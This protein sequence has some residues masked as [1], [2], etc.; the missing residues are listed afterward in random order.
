MAGWSELSSV[1]DADLSAAAAV[2]ASPAALTSAAFD[3]D[4]E[5][6]WTGNEH[7][8]VAS[9]VGGEI[10]KYT[11]FRAHQGPVRQLIPV[12]T[13]V[14]S[15]GPQSVRLTNRR[16][17]V[18]WTIS[19]PMLTQ[20][21]YCM[22]P[23]ALRHSDVIVA[24][25]QR[26]ALMVNVDRGTIIRKFDCDSDI[27]VLRRSQL[28][29][30]GTATGEVMLRDPR[31]FRVEHAVQ[32]H[33]GT[34]SDIAV[35]DNYLLTCGYS[36]RHGELVIDPLVKV[37][38]LRSMRPL[39]P[40]SFVAGP[41]FLKLHPIKP[42]SVF[43]AAQ[44]GQFQTCDIG[45]PAAQVQFYQANT[46]S[47]ITAFD[48]SPSGEL[49]AFGD[50]SSV[51]SLW[52]DSMHPRVNMSG[53]MPEMA[54]STHLPPS[55][56]MTDD[57]HVL[58]AIERVYVP[59][60]LSAWPSHMIFEVGRPAEAIDTEVLDQMKTVDFV[61][62][63]PNPGTRL[64]NQVSSSYRKY[65]TA[66]TMHTDLDLDVDP[67]SDNEWSARA[68]EMPKYYRKVEI[69]Y[70]KFGVEDFDFGY[71][72]KT[73]FG[74]L[75]THITNSYCNA[76]LQ[77][78]RFLPGVGVA[79][80]LH[81]AQECTKEYCLCCELG[82]LLRMLEAAD[83]ANCQASNFLR[84]FGTIPEAS[85][86]GLFEPETPEPRTSYSALI[87][88]FNRF[89][90]EQ[91]HQEC[92]STMLVRPTEMEKSLAGDETIGEDAGATSPIKQLFGIPMVTQSQC[93][94]GEM[95]QR[96]SSPFTVDMAYAAKSVDMAG[97][98]SRPF[99]DI[100]RSSLT[101]ESQTRAWCDRCR[102][103][104]PT[105]QHKRLRGLPVILN[106]NSALYKRED[107]SHWCSHGAADQ[108]HRWLPKRLFIG[109]QKDGELDVR[110]A[111]DSA[112]EPDEALYN[113]YAIFELSAVISQIQP[114][115]ELPHL[116]AHIR[117]PP[118]EYDSL[119]G[120]SSEWYLFNDF[121]VRGVQEAE[122]L[123]L[124]PNWKLPAVLCYVREN[125]Y[126]L[127][128]DV[129]IP[130]YAD[131][132]ILRNSESMSIN[133]NDACKQYRLLE[134]DEA[135]GPGSVC[136]IDAE[137][138]ALSQEKT[139]T[140]ADG[141]RTVVRPIRLSL[142]RV[143]VVRGDG[144]LEGVPFIDDYITTSEPIVDYLT[145]FSGIEAADLDPALSSHHLV[146][147]KTAYKKLR[148]LLDMGCVFVGHG[149]KKDFRIIN[150]MVPPEQVID[151]VDIFHLKNRQRKISLRFLA[152]YLLGESIQTS[153]HD[154]IEDARTAL[155][156]YKKYL[157]L[158]AK[159]T[160]DRVLE[161]IYAEGWRRNWKVG[162]KDEP[163]G[164]S[165]LPRAPA[166]PLAIVHPDQAAAASVT[167]A[168]ATIASN[169][170]TDPTSETKT[171][172]KSKAVPAA[173][174]MLPPGD[175][176]MH[177]ETADDD[178]LLSPTLLASPSTA[179]MVA[180]DDDAAEARRLPLFRATTSGGT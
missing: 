160:F 158:R 140:S 76:E 34:I 42:L 18:Q 77:A 177:A 57:R 151:T 91:L 161:G 55:A 149:L 166:A 114:E 54:D 124:L 23:S 132:N 29:C 119:D 102:Q 146:Q 74:G 16:G 117:V 179:E 58:W 112:L 113:Q 81:T 93:Q 43:I 67:F 129:P 100:L 13:G 87:Q 125:A 66:E 88:S 25:R 30:C 3:L 70:S 126:D 75:E 106:I 154:S 174:H 108:S 90:L 123:D 26:C 148:L 136:A 61:G 130:P 157:E 60:L 89:I 178:A 71:Y 11:S 98:H 96:N 78:L 46:S 10:H 15:V 143:S 94:C 156:L 64:R 22:A 65:R 6:L 21:L 135:I 27:V 7:G 51:V 84:A 175:D 5:L 82:F 41:S 111:G 128:E 53:E 33:T 28:V 44:D 104:Q 73:F 169:N 12:A 101:R 159:G 62:Y 63:A 99:T 105:I 110:D 142:A 39:A 120:D 121:L 118:M 79:A 138:V 147:L 176:D 2:T 163:P 145:E 97:Q 68:G 1:C 20:D 56:A 131:P 38:D 127:L 180:A 153:G 48:I 37:Y 8:R 36:E 162:E 137:F 49:V 83:G 92:G 150:I 172:L 164:Q 4:Q 80:K 144:A 86:L 72:N 134:E 40:L 122:A 14:L 32:A 155:R 152:W 109:L 50:A 141:V 170:D 17:M 95:T 167:P 115:K 47:Y 69:K 107:R 31:T 116:V 85:A 171:G 19:D 139:E 52:T 9:Y 45:N 59:P 24:G 35:T 173:L 103:Y 165:L 168:P 133:T